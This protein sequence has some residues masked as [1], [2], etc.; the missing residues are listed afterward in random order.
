DLA[1]SCGGRAVDEQPDACVEVL[2]DAEGPVVGAVQL[3]RQPV[4]RLGPGFHLQ[5]PAVRLR[6]VEHHP[7][8]VADLDGE[9]VPVLEADLHPVEVLAL[10][11]DAE[12]VRGSLRGRGGETTP[13]LVGQHQEDLAVA[14]EVHVEERVV[15][16]AAHA[17][18]LERGDA[19]GDC[20]LF[21]AVADEVDVLVRRLLPISI[22]AGA[23][24]SGSY[25]PFP[26]A[27]NTR[28]SPASCGYANA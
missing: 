18:A 1:R 14:A 6:D 7:V 20:A 24:T 19:D 21:V 4:G 17:S 16:V 25:V 27:T 28:S 11:A 22:H 12:H 2:D 3:D 9:V 5:S 10:D 13:V 15:L 26:S 23:S 8:A